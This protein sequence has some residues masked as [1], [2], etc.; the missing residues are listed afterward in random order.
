MIWIGLWRRFN[1]KKGEIGKGSTTDRKIREKD[2][3]LGEN[4]RVAERWRNWDGCNTGC[5]KRGLGTEQRASVLCQGIQANLS[6]HSEWSPQ[7][8]EW[9]V[10][11]RV[12]GAQPR[13][14]QRGANGG[15]GSRVCFN[16]LMKLFSYLLHSAGFSISGSWWN[17][18]SRDNGSI[19]CASKWNLTFSPL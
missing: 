6:G 4:K 9:Q 1:S 5:M 13:P 3:E 11:H 12:V 18:P 14:E 15:W 10:A 8:K 2:T 17:K 19:N 16:D 7:Q